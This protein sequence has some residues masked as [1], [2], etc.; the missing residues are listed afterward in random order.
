MAKRYAFTPP[1]SKLIRLGA[2]AILLLL[3]G[4]TSYYTIPAE[5]EG[6]VLRFGR[7]YATATSGL[8]FKLPL[9]ID[10]VLIVPVKRQLKQE[11]GFGTTGS[12]NASQ[13][14]DPS[15]WAG[16][17]T[18]VT[19]DL[20]VALVEWVLQYRI[21]E[22]AHYLFNVRSPDAT[23]RDASESVMREVVGDRTVDEVI[24]IGRQGIEDEALQK[25]QALVAE[26]K[27]GIRI[28]QV[29]LKNVNPP[30]RV[31]AS[32]NEVNQAQQERESAINVANGEYNKSIPRARGQAAQSITAAEGYAKQRVNQAA[33]DVSAFNAI[34]TEYLKAPDVTRRRLYLET[35]QEVLSK[36]RN[37]IIIDANAKGLVP[38]FNVTGAAP[39]DTAAQG[40][41]DTQK[42]VR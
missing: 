30:E 19:G 31:Q 5:S 6:V 34:L 16:E 7:L 15:E 18:M 29:Q 21:E 39:F 35:M 22:P 3:F 14:T 11:F 24:T 33:G 17:K 13:V 32:F 23:L 38:L 8:H 40:S 10:S 12:S 36:V 26:Y 4:W 25:L 28:D 41:G 20:N 9:G 1:S 2:G 42:A 37:K 27:M